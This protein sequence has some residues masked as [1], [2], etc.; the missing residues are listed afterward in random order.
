MIKPEKITPYS[1]NSKSF[2]PTQRK[3]DDM[4]RLRAVRPLTFLDLPTEIRLIIYHNL[5]VNSRTI[6][7]S[8]YFDCEN[9]QTMGHYFDWE[10]FSM[11][12]HGP[13]SNSWERYNPHTA[14]KWQKNPGT[15]TCS[16]T[17]QLLATC[18][19]IGEESSTVLYGENAFGLY[20]HIPDHGDGRAIEA[21]FF[22]GQH[23][24]ELELPWPEKT[25]LPRGKDSKFTFDPSTFAYSFAVDKIRK[26]R[27]VID[28]EFEGKAV[29]GPQY[30]LFKHALQLTCERLEDVRLRHL[31]I[32]LRSRHPMTDFCMLDSLMILRNL[33]RVTFEAE[34]KNCCSDDE[35]LPVSLPPQYAGFF[36]RQLENS[37]PPLYSFLESYNFQAVAAF[38][39]IEDAPPMVWRRFRLL[40]KNRQ[41][42]GCLEGPFEECEHRIRDQNEQ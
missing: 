34:R 21:S 17:G 9:E 42:H 41:R 29:K 6:G 1:L 40:T 26:L 39:E 19:K 3:A 2:L 18:K 14:T 20:I 10:Q 4:S 22:E 27:L 24:A 31:N 32:E 11:D 30:Y 8:R 28:L 25:L 23:I 35:Q 33:Q 5:L 36:K 7:D 38:L 15:S 37:H 12:W 13:G 16:L